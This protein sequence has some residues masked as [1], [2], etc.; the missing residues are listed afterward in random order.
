MPVTLLVPLYLSTHKVRLAR[1]VLTSHAR[2]ALCRWRK[3]ADST[4]TGVIGPRLVQVRQ[5]GP[6]VQYRVL[7]RGQD[8]AESEDA[9]LL[10]DYFNCSTDLAELC[11]HWS[12][13]DPRFKA[14]YPYF[15]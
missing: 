10:S 14:L 11:Q 8:A 7:A 4:Y 1:G 3:V 13:R 12:S 6:E 9:A 5:L 2:L 15:R